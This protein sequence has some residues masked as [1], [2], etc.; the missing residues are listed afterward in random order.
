MLKRII[1]FLVFST[2]SLGLC[3]ASET[4]KIILSAKICAGM[5]LKN[6]RKTGN[7]AKPSELALLAKDRYYRYLMDEDLSVN[8]KEVRDN[9]ETAV[10]KAEKKFEKEEPGVTQS[11]ILKLKLGLMGVQKDLNE[12][13][14]DLE[15]SKV[16]LLEYLG[17]DRDT[18][19]EFSED[20]LKKI[21][22]EVPSLESCRESAR[23]NHSSSSPVE[24]ETAYI[25]LMESKENIGFL[26]EG[27]KYSRGLLVVALANF[28]MGIGEG[29]DLFEALYIYNRAV[30]DYVKGVYSFNMA[31]ERLGG[32]I[33]E[34]LVKK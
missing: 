11:D 5:A 1:F 4:K 24:L 29:K 7:P 19:L 33:G 21:N 18:P 31:V 14:K 8:A 17:L 16:E 27:R 20:G 22:L 13:E 12:T 32:A 9:F 3:H 28:D 2:I 23:K 10:E 25:N 15:R 30:R 6:P 34:E 26:K